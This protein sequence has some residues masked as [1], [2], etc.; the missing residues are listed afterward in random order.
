MT[1]ETL[2]VRQL[3]RATLARQMLLERE[4]LS[5]VAAVERLAGMQAQLARPP[6]VGLWTRVEGFQREELVA[7]FQERTVVRGIL[8]RSTIHLMSSADYLRFWRTLQPMLSADIRSR[9]N[10][11]DGLEPERVAPVA[12]ELLREQPR[13]I[14]ELAQALQAAFPGI[15]PRTLAHIA[16]A[17]LP[18]LFMPGGDAHWAFPGNAGFTLA[19]DWLSEPPAPNT[20]RH[21]LVL[22][23]LAAFGPASV[24][25][26]QTWS[27]LTRM[28]AVLD[29]LR[30]QLH[31]F[32]DE[33][34]RELFD[35]PDAPRPPSDTPAPPRF[36]PNFDNLVLSHADRSRVLP[37][38]H[39]RFMASKNGM[40]PATVLID[41]F[42]GATWRTERARNAATL[43]ITPF[44]PL[45]KHVTNEL[46]EEGEALLR[47]VEEDA[48]TFDVRIEPPAT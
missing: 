25:D 42:V 1:L 23:Y 29:E 27:K 22:R 31:S 21:A 43:R 13:T 45:P 4:R 8:M 18:L 10:R 2:T 19:T 38:Q 41:G 9:L 26:V 40:V 16:R 39:R 30:P 32:R 3:N 17:E 6:F 48:A 5:A 36:L 12:C 14:T 24:A 28:S 20:A 11:A 7:G 35:L 33:Q 34:G 47:F 37:E 15:E 46:A 44:E